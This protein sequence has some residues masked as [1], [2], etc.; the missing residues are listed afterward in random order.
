MLGLEGVE[1][2]GNDK[3]C[4]LDP[5]S[6]VEKVEDSCPTVTMSLPIPVLFCCELESSS[7]EPSGNCPDKDLRLCRSGATRPN[8]L[9]TLDANGMRD[10]DSESPVRADERF[11]RCWELCARKFL[12]FLGD[13]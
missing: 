11:L 4:R 1:T 12:D 13:I 5:P 9:P 10:E 6:K 2:A 3:L 7:L 8:A